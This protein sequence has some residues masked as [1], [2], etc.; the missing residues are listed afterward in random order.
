MFLDVE[1]LNPL[2]EGYA[3]ALGR[4]L[5]VCQHLEDC[6]HHVMETWAV[7]DAMRAGTH[8]PDELRAIALGLQDLSL[9][10][11][12]RR[13]AAAE[14]FGPDRADVVE[15]GRVARNWIVHGGATVITVHYPMPLVTEA[16]A[17]FSRRVDGLCEA[18]ALLSMASYIICEREPVPLGARAENARQLRAWIMAPIL[19]GFGQLA[20]VPAP[21]AT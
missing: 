15:R 2:L 17:E 16:L 9:G 3:A 19:E 18:T 10:R 14:D 11:S 6:A 5:V 1:G 13:L 12:V 7:T 8:D 21:P 4:A 20:G